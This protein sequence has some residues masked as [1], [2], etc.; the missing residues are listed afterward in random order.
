M[1][2]YRG[3]DVGTAK[4][5]PQEQAE[6]AHHMLDLSDPSE[7]WSVTRWASEARRAIEGIEGRGHRPLLVAGT[8]LYLRALV[9]DLAPPGRY[10]DVRAQL[11]PESDTVVL[12]ARLNA[13][14]PIAASRME[15]TNRRRVIRALEVSIGSGRPFSSFGKGL[16][17]HPPTDWCL[18]GLWLPRWEV[19]KRVEKRLTAMLE[20]G[21]LDETRRLVDAPCA[22]SRTAGQ[23]LGYKE[24]IRHL[25]GELSLSA[26]VEEATGRTRAYS[27]RQRMWWR[28]DPR[29]HWYGV[30]SNPLAVIPRILGDWETP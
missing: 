5:T 15:P 25:A 11:E 9:D 13:L 17:V 7:E 26:A 16:E 28:R 3:M 1:Q 6:I 18:L 21:L 12:H 23:A 4:P 19:A 8:G 20:G 14:D 27:R 22:M 2:V 10:P 30:A 29:I 24:L